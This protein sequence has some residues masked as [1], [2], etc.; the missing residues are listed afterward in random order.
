[1]CQL[2][3]RAKQQNSSAPQL[4]FAS[5]AYVVTFVASCCTTSMT[6]FRII[7]VTFTVS[8]MTFLRVLQGTLTAPCSTI[9]ANLLQ[10]FLVNFCCFMLHCQHD[11]FP[12]P[13]CNFHGFVHDVSQGPSSNSHGSVQHYH[14]D[15]SPSRSCNFRGFVLHCQH[16]SFSDPSCNF[17]GFV[18]DFL[19]VFYVAVTASRC[20]VSTALL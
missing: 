17:R 15:S 14:R 13:S 5:Y 3:L 6:L 18:H 7:H 2:T 9:I 4:R 10:V 8:C 11:S 19:W 16:D 20:T 12:D 1:M